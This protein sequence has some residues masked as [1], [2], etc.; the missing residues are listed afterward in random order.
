MTIPEGQDISYDINYWSDPYL[1]FP[2]QNLPS[3]SAFSSAFPG[4]YDPL[5][6]TPEK[7]YSSIGGQV[8]N[9]Y[10]SNPKLFQNTCALRVSKALNYSGVSIPSGTDR[11]K[12]SDGKYYFLSSGALL[13]WMKKTFGTPT[14]N[15]HFT[16]TQGGNQGINF[17]LLL[18]GKTGIYLMTPNIPGGCPLTPTSQPTGFCASGHADKIDNGHCDG[19]CYFNIIGGVSEIFV[20]ELY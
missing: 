7:L 18:F 8:L 5:Y 1:T 11:F 12:G 10:N 6:N 2:T 16:G 19:G 15:N 3:W 9:M 17:P 20:W 14:G 13:S 4:H